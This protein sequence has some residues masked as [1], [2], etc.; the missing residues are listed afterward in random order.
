MKTP[1]KPILTNDALEMVS[2]RWKTG[3]SMRDTE[4]R[5]RW[6]LEIAAYMGVLTSRPEQEWQSDSFVPMSHAVIENITA[7]EMLSL[8]RRKTFQITSDQF[9]EQQ[10]DKGTAI[11]KITDAGKKLDAAFDHFVRTDRTWKRKWQRMCRQKN[12]I[13]V[14]VAKLYK[15][16]NGI[17]EW[18]PVNMFNFVIDPAALS[19]NDAAWCAHE[20]LRDKETW[21]GMIEKGGMYSLPSGVTME[22]VRTESSKQLE[23]STA[24][25]EWDP[26]RPLTQSAGFI[27][28]NTKVHLVEY[29]SKDRVITMLNGKWIIRDE[30]NGY[31]FLPYVDMHCLPRQDNFYSFGANHFSLD[32]Q[33]YLNMLMNMELDAIKLTMN[34]PRWTPRMAG[35][36]GDDRMLY[37]GKKLFCRDPSMI[38]EMRFDNVVAMGGGLDAR[39]RYYLQNGTSVNDGNMGQST[40]A[41]NDTAV[42]SSNMLEEANKRLSMMIDLDEECIEDFV[43]KYIK[44]TAIGMEKAIKVRIGKSWEELQKTDFEIDFAITVNTPSRMENAAVKAQQAVALKQALANDPYVNQEELTRRVLEAY[45]QENIDALMLTPQEQTELIVE[46]AKIEAGAKVGIEMVRRHVAEKMAAELG[47]A[48]TNGQEQQPTEGPGEDPGAI[49]QEQGQPPE[50]PPGALVQPNQS[51]EQMNAAI[52]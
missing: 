19:I 46:K 7:K 23:G 14:S 15:G 51:Q 40:P 29:W 13:G 31:G 26:K 22:D 37:P 11:R 48:G 49:P 16:D 2:H 21:L 3:A 4:A 18:E 5:E 47:D 6:N 20:Y 35:L 36:E 30:E 27:D 8:Y 1:T 50:M 12:S 52:Q 34:P 41:M 25:Y 45:Q 44:I 9:E 28:Y 10:D 43:Y 33:R 17:C 32:M 39:V 42:G 24:L 38:R